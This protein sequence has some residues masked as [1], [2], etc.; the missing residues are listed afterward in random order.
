MS[1]ANRPSKKQHELLSF[2]DG[3][4]RMNGYGPS[5]REVMRALNYKSVSTV[6]THIDSLIRKG[7]L[8]KRDHSARSLSVVGKPDGDRTQKTVAPAEQKWLIDQVMQRFDAYEAQPEGKL[9]DQLCIL[10][11]ALTVL[12]MDDAAVAAKARLTNLSPTRPKPVVRA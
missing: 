8:A 3:F 11:G 6:A 10:T 1:V 12:G 2:I 7:W 4:I 9:Y 5:Y